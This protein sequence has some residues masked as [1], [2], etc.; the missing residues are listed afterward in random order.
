MELL[1]LPTCTVDLSRQ[2]LLRPDGEE[3]ISLREAH[4]LAYLA[5]RSG[6]LVSRE[7]LET[8][9]WEFRLGVRSQAVPVAVRR[10]RA[11]IEAD[12]RD[13]RILLTEYGRGWRLI[14]EPPP[15]EGPPTPTLLGRATALA[16]V[17][18]GWED[19]DLQVVVGPGG[20]GKTTLA[21]AAMPPGAVFVDLQ[22]ATTEAQCLET[23]RRMVPGLQLDHSTP[24]AATERIHHRLK[25]LPMTV[26]DNAE[27]VIEP[28]AGLVAQLAGARI[29]VTSR[30]PLGLPRERIVYL[31]PLAPDD[32][33]ELFRRRVALAGGADP[34]PYEGVL[35]VVERVDRLPLAIELVAPRAR[36]LP[37]QDLVKHVERGLGAIPRGRGRPTRHSS[38][39]TCLQ[40]SWEALTPEAQEVLRAAATFATTSSLD[41]L[42]QVAGADPLDALDVLIEAAMIAVET[43]GVFAVRVLVRAFVSELEGNEA[44]VDRHAVRMLERLDAIGYATD[45]LARLVRL[46]PELKRVV[47]RA[48]PG[49]LV[50]RAALGVHEALRG[51]GLPSVAQEV[52]LTA[53]DRSTCESLRAELELELVGVTAPLDPQRA[54]RYFRRI[55]PD[56]LPDLAGWSYM[57]TKVAVFGGLPFP[58]VEAHR[59]A[60]EAAPTGRALTGLALARQLAGDEDEAEVLI[61]RA[62]A[63]AREEP[64]VQ[65]R[66]NT[67]RM[68][69][70]ITSRVGGTEEGE[71]A[72]R[73]ALR[74]AEQAGMRAEAAFCRSNLSVYL[75]SR[76]RRAADAVFERLERE[77]TVLGNQASAHQARGNRALNRWALGDGPEAWRLLEQVDFH[78]IRPQVRAYYWVFRQSIGFELGHVVRDSLEAALQAQAESGTAHAELLVSLLGARLLGWPLLRPLASLEQ[79]RLRPD[80]ADLVAWLRANRPEDQ[81]SS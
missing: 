46:A 20:V 7:E 38:M 73:E 30:V 54:A 80:L 50:H 42:E 34:L 45:R 19:G 76:D 6:E 49:P 57:H 67:L 21:R 24:T 66:L 58:P 60:V 4:L 1:H 78:Q 43:P 61:R 29:L 28:L 25:A 75:A 10:L 37:L 70:Q 12:P 17:E 55:D 71:A 5:A 59:A 35:E 64:D 2:R 65:D 22:E 15:T 8:E 48:T 18:A 23:I 74:L 72:L 63:L 14:C 33:V 77:F 44:Y 69:E 26:L 41:D 36:M 3:K 11:R 39:R 40:W 53:I 16:S 62:L 27:Q 9:V 47:E 52:L 51:Q 13:P 68:F 31:E 56:M 81:S 79:E 32:A